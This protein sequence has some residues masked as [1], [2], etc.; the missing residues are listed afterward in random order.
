MQ[1]VGAKRK[2]GADLGSAPNS[3]GISPVSWFWPSP[4]IR[5]I[6]QIAQLPRNLAR[7][8]VGAERQDVE[9]QAVTQLYRNPTGQPITVLAVES[10]NLDNRPS[11]GGI[12]PLRLLLCI[13][14]NRNSAS[15]L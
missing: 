12:S 11:S 5:Q 15:S 6:R 14:K 1:P 9:I 3:T 10:V 7:Q 8:P 2:Q 13:S 4:S